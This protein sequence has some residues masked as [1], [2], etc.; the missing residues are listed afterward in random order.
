MSG[1]MING[2]PAPL[3]SRS[4]SL[5]DRLATYGSGRVCAAD[6][7][8]TVLSRYNPSPFCCLHGHGWARQ[9]A[10]QRQYRARPELTRSC[11]NPACESEFVT[12]NPH[13]KYCS[14]RCRMRAFQ[15]R[16]TLQRRQTA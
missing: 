7:C 2:R 12:T 10:E 16:L 13:R 1:M 6:G 11:A 9:R 4:T 5:E 15:Q 14:D 8:A 3:A